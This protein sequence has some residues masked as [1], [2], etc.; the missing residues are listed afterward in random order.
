M[1]RKCIHDVIVSKGLWGRA[2]Q[3]YLSCVSFTDSCIG[4]IL[5][6]YENS[7]ER[8]NT[9][10]VLWS[11]HGWSL[12]SKFHW[13]KMALWEEET[14]CTFMVHICLLYTSRCV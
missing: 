9:I 11:D 7:P 10:I 14:K 6:A 5:E 8:D 12:G 3:A 1:N 2:V 13:Q 4:K